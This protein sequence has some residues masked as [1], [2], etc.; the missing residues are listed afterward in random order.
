MC[1][2]QPGGYLVHPSGNASLFPNEGGGGTDLTISRDEPQVPSPEFMSSP[3][4]KCVENTA[5]QIVTG[6]ARWHNV[7]YSTGAFQHAADS[8]RSKQLY[9]Q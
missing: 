5:C 2:I 1:V 9:S 3:F 7:E 4:S 8:Q 6:E